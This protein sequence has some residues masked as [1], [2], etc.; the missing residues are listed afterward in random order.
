[1][2][3]DILETCWDN[4]KEDEFPIDR[5][6]TIVEET[7]GQPAMSVENTRFLINEIVRRVGGVYLEVGV[8]VGHSLMSAAVFN[9]CAECI[10]IENF[11]E[12]ADQK[13]LEYVIKHHMPDN[14]TILHG[15]YEDIVPR[16]KEEYANDV[17]VY[18]YDGHHSYWATL[19]G[20]YMIQPLMAPKSYILL[21]D[22]VMNQ[23]RHAKN[24]FVNAN[25]DWK[26]V[27]E[28]VPPRELLIA[29]TFKNWYNGFCVLEKV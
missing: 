9:E 11:T 8:F 21:D 26:Q 2:I 24:R 10:G 15:S 3:Y 4:W 17:N 13:R 6:M 5:R 20:L 22:T 14:A 7:I 23:V 1:M 29:N 12:H 25:N 28:I 19:L 18:Y 16:L 27:L